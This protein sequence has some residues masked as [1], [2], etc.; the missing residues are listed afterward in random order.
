VLLHT[1]LRVD[2]F[3]SLE[4]NQYKCKHLVNIHRKGADVT[5]KIFLD[6]PIREVLDDF[7][8]RKQVLPEGLGAG[9]AIVNR[10]GFAGGSNT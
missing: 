3:C 7:A 6:T 4:R 1:A 9:T 5:P 2:E 8:P 10:A